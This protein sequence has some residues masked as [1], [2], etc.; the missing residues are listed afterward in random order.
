MHHTH[1]RWRR[2][3]SHLLCATPH[4][5]CTQ[6]RHTRH[7]R[8]THPTDTRQRWEHACCEHANACIHTPLHTRHTHNTHLRYTH[9]HKHTLTTQAKT[10][11]ETRDRCDMPHM[12]T[13]HMLS[14]G[15]THPNGA[16]IIVLVNPS[17]GCS[18]PL[19]ESETR[20]YL[21]TSCL[22]TYIYIA[23]R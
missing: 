8:H 6:A 20:K 19:F 2:S 21:L 5:N 16:A 12:H 11:T 10:R 23:E 17:C 22:M 15:H 14:S 3:N 7:T 1:D 18:K 9:T 4:S 13:R